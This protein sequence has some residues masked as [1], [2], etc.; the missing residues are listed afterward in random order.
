MPP[1]LAMSARCSARGISMSLKCQSVAVPARRP[2]GGPI[3]VSKPLQCRMSARTSR[4]RAASRSA[5]NASPPPKRRPLAIRSLIRGRGKSNGTH[6]TPWL[7]KNFT[8]GPGGITTIVSKP[9][10]S[11]SLASRAT[12]RCGPPIRGSGSRFTTRT[13]RFVF[14]GVCTIRRSGA[15]VIRFRDSIV[16]TAATRPTRCRAPSHG[17]EPRSVRGGA[18]NLGASH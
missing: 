3:S 2:A 9:S 14:L 7:S 13:G 18:S 6:R 16:V 4:S 1:K 12:R 17:L 5:S 10:G 8:A 11:I 15:T